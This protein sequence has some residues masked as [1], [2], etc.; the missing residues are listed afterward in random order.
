MFDAM[1]GMLDTI[2]KIDTQRPLELA[3]LHALLSQ[4]VNPA[5]FGA[6]ELKKGL[7][8]KSIVYPKVYRVTPTITVKGNQ[9]TIKRVEDSS[10]TKVTVGGV[11]FSLDKDKRGMNAMK[12][13][14]A[15]TEYFQA[16][17]GAVEHALADQ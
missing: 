17:C 15:G 14:Q 2:R 5:Q 9:V 4:R 7:L 6:P 16:L 3:E 8:G 12:T 1:K 10:E 11:G 13:A